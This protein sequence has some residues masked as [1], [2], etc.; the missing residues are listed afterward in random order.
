MT[1]LAKQADIVLPAADPL[2]SEGSVIDYLGR[3]KEVRQAVAPVGD[4][5][6]HRDI[7]AGIAKEKGL[8]VKP[9]KVSD[10]K[11]LSK[12]KVKLAIG[13]FKKKEGMD[14]DLEE[15]MRSVNKP[16]I[17]GSRLLWLKEIEKTVAV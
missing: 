10:T 8:S 7:I 14:A 13:E 11:K 5:L 6:Q 17:T 12:A 3:F 4:V 15:Y 1:E 2:E 9:S 16:V